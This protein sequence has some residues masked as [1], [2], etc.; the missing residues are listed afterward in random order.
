[1][2]LDPILERF[3]EATPVAVM[4]RATLERALE[5]GWAD[6]LFEEYRERQ[7]TRELLFSTTVELMAVVALGLQPSIH[8]AARAREDLG[9]SLAA[10]YDKINGTEVGLSR[11]LVAGSAE[12]LGET[13]KALRNGQ[14]P[15]MRGYQVRV[16][17][18]NHLPGSEKRLAAL[19][20]LRGAAL[21]GHSLVVYDPDARL[22]TDVVP[23]ADAYAQERT[24]VPM[25]IRT[26]TAGQVWM[27]DRNFS[28]TGI[29]FGVH[30]SDGAF[31]IREHSKSPNPEELGTP[32]HRGRV[33]AG[34]LYEQAVRLENDDGEQLV[35]RRIE[36]RLHS[37]TEDGETTI[38]ILTNLP[39]SKS[40]EEV[41]CAYRSRWKIENMFQW[42]ESVLHSEVRTLGHPP[43]ALFAF[44]VA[45]VAYN[46]LSVVQSAIEQAHDIKSDGDSAISLYYVMN[47]VK[48]TYNGMMVIVPSMSWQAIEAMTP[49]QTGK[50][51]LRVARSV[52]PVQFRK[53]KRGPKKI[54]KK[55]YAPGHV[56]RSH[57]ATARLLGFAKSPKKS[58]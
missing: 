18:G 12:R 24:L 40:A 27:A 16:I 29:M 3:I 56:A 11:A 53:T 4:A 44:A 42:L 34:E 58:P 7:Y 35:F 52:D 30:L 13:A 20:G 50:F 26:V 25:I 41:A 38:R 33:A 47:T 55:G 17:D 46:A 49:A 31:I 10:L 57:V 19:R 8:A 39:R 14:T 2:V 21:P 6:R 37:P 1:M 51:L 5:A 45:A 23:C 28:T 32:K 54:T 36:L 22:V 15:V 9:V 43:A 48:G